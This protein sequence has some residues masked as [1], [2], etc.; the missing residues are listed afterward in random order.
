MNTE[1]LNDFKKVIKKQE[2]K[3]SAREAVMKYGD[4]WRL[5]GHTNYPWRESITSDQFEAA[6]MR[7]M[8]DGTIGRIRPG[9]AE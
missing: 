5:Y 8:E 2:T 4:K 7:L 3:L 6:T 1:A 9:D